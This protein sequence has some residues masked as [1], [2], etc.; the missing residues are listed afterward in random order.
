VISVIPGRY[1]LPE[2][3]FRARGRFGL[4][5]AAN[6]VLQGPAGAAFSRT[7]KLQGT[8]GTAFLKAESPRRC[9]ELVFRGFV[10][11]VQQIQGLSNIV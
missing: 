6:A 8:V 9:L 10:V 11:P 1:K 5:C 4:A 2:Q 7:W 3:P